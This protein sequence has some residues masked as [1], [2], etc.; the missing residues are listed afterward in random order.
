MPKGIPNKRYTAEF[1]GLAVEMMQ[2]TSA[3]Q[4][5]SQTVWD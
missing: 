1:T 3:L 5:N 2:N 4:E